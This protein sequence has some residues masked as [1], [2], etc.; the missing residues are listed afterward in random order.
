M[1]RVAAWVCPGE[2]AAH[3]LTGERFG[4]YDTPNAP[5]RRYKTTEERLVAEFALLNFA[6]G[7]TAVPGIKVSEHVL[8]ISAALEA[9]GQSGA[10]PSSSTKEILSHWAKAEPVL[11]AIA[12]AFAGK[13]ANGL[14]AV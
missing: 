1:S 5:V 9:T 13:S 8:P 3:K 4:R 12:D 14:Q 7:Q 6:Q 10:I 11:N 2:D